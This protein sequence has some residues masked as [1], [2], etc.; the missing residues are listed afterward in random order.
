MP[1]SERR[2]NPGS[3]DRRAQRRS[4]GTLALGATMAAFLLLAL[5][6]HRHA[7]VALRTA[8]VDTAD[9]AGGDVAVPTVERTPAEER[10]IQ[11]VTF[12]FDSTQSD[13]QTLFPRA[14]G[15]PYHGAT[16]EMYRDFTRTGCGDALVT[17]PVYC[18]ADRAVYVDLAMYA[19][20]RARYGTAGD[21][22]EAY[23][24]AHEFG[25]HVEHLLGQSDGAYAG[26]RDDSIRINA[27][28]P[29]AELLADCY[30]GV[31]M[32]AMNQGQVLDSAELSSGIRA[33]VAVTS[34]WAQRHPALHLASDA[35]VYRSPETREFWFRRGFGSGDPS[36]C[37]SP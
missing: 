11:F 12:V 1:G 35:F 4:G 15:A 3:G 24:I 9:S 20:L 22:G 27:G 37:R 25:H 14:F 7:A 13:W 17:G 16:M 10:E 30:A 32:H 6:V 19:E 29:R 23:L 21:V 34:E 18:G 36:F 2:V 31:W 33:A 8:M 26:G 5:A 28:T